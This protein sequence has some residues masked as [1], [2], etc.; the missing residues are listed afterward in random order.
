MQVKADVMKPDD[1]PD[2][3]MLTGKCVLIPDH[4]SSCLFPLNSIKSQL[5]FQCLF[6]KI[7]I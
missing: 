6:T 7:L 5:S 1:E 3:Y 4:M 2:E